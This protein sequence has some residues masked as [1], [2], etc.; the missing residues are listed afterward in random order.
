MDM[1][2]SLQISNYKS[3]KK[4]DLDCRRINVLVGEPNVGKSNILEALD[5]SYLSW[6]LAADVN[7]ELS[8]HELID[9]KKYFRVNNVADLFNDGDVSKPIIISHPGYSTDTKLS[10]KEDENYSVNTHPK[11]SSFEIRSGG[12]HTLFDKDFKPTETQQFFSSPIQPFRFKESND[13]H[14]NGN[15][16]SKLMAPYGNNLLEVIKHNASFRVL[17]SELITGFGLELNIDSSNHR[18]FVQRKISPGIVYNMKYESIADTLR[19]I[20]FY[21]AAIRHNS[22]QVITLEEPDAHSFP[23]FVSLLADE[24]IEN[25]KNQ[26]FI[27]THSPYLLNNLIENTPE[28]DLSVFVCGFD[29][30]KGTTAKR[31]SGTELSELLDYGVDIFFNINRYL[32]D[33]VEHSS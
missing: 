28:E 8:G 1:I 16:I 29:K 22:A 25:S 32:D 2:G 9:I 23:K 15:Y 24:L 12:N 17:I 10:F 14:D 26:F 19:R 31:L 18:L 30:E 13:F 27:A 4:V 6:M 11:L 21:V 20:I 5:L 33:G 7:N 3:I